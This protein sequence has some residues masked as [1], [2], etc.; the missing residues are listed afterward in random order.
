MKDYWSEEEKK[1]VN[2][3]KIIITIVVALLIISGIVIGVF[4]VQNSNFREWT[5]KTIFRKEVKQ[6][7]LA[8]IELKEGENPIVYA[9]NQTIGVLNKNEFSLYN[10]TGKEE[11]TVTL[12]I[13]NPLFDS[14]NRYLAIGENKGKKLY[15]ME[16]K[17]IAWE[18][19]IEGEISQVHVNKNGYVAVATT[20]TIHKTVIAMYDPH[21]E[22]L[23][24]IYVSFNRV[25]DI[26]ISSDNKYLAIAEI[27][28]SGTMIESNIKIV[29]IDKAKT[30]PDNYIVHTYTGEKNELVTNIKYQTKNQ[31][32]CLYPD[33]ITKITMDEKVETL[34]E[35]Q[36]KKITFQAIELNDHIVTV[37]EKSSGLFTA[38][39]IVTI[40]NTENKNTTTYAADSVTK[41]IYTNH[42][43]IALNLGTEIEFINTSGWL[44]KRYLAK[45]EITQITMSGNLAGIIYR[46]R[47]E[48]VN[49]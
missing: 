44:V 35:N 12:E 26:A 30:D 43:I 36:T 7:N 14:E 49:L 48:I 37:E 46:D 19:T 42:D 2:R 3:K 34:S 10:N 5:D 16:D 9:F 8:T 45:Q 15:L 23:F 29:S 25:G 39:S 20:G 17:D 21:G 31:L 22:E 38:D 40:T 32:V 1:S 24:N 33:K 11:K 41:E 47:I 27:D 13:T 6:D 18:K 28:T 4:Y